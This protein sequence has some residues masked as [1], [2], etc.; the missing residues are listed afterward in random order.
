M[1]A[2]ECIISNNRYP[3]I[4][5]I[6]LVSSNFVLLPKSDIKYGA[7]YTIDITPEIKINKLNIKQIEYISLISSSFSFIL[8]WTI[9]GINTVN[10]V[11][12]IE[13]NIVNNCN[14]N[15]YWATISKDKY[16]EAIKIFPFNIKKAPKDTTPN[17]LALWKIILNSFL[18][19][20]EFIFFSFSL[21][22]FVKNFLEDKI[23][24]TIT[25]ARFPNDI[26]IS[27]RSK[28]NPKKENNIKA[29]LENII[30]LLASAIIPFPLSNALK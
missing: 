29:I 22:S 4:N 26:P 18:S 2:F 27:P 11:V 19:I 17:L 8:F 15:P 30:I 16:F 21:S 28:Y 10:N 14:D 23:L 24:I 12:A 25:E 6:L 13:V 5:N 20:L 7:T 9:L 1:A 3:P